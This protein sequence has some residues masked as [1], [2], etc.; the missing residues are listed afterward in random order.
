[1]KDVAADK[2]GDDLNDF[3]MERLKVL[4]GIRIFSSVIFEHLLVVRLWYT[5][6]RAAFEAL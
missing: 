5:A 4:E 1:M 2:S 6:L 3:N